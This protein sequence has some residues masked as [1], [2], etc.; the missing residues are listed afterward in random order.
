MLHLLVK[1]Y[2]KIDGRGFDLDTLNGLLPF[3][4]SYINSAPSY[5]LPEL[6]FDSQHLLSVPEASTIKLGFKKAIKTIVSYER[7]G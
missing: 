4:I 3:F 7:V 1:H 5:S 2:K 6:G